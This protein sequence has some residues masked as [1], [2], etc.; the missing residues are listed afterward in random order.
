MLDSFSGNNTGQRFKREGKRIRQLGSHIYKLSIKARGSKLNAGQVGV[1]SI[2]DL[3]A[4]IEESIG[5]LCFG[6]VGGTEKLR[7]C[8]FS[9]QVRLLSVSLVTR[10]IFTALGHMTTDSAV[11]SL[12]YLGPQA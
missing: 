3:F 4:F 8:T 10:C 2:S 5:A 6:G 7:T 12:C 9:G 11:L 1:L